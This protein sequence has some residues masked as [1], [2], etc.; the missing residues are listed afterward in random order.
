MQRFN[1]AFQAKK[2][3]EETI[4]DSRG[5]KIGTIRLKPAAILFMPKGT[6]KF[7]S[8]TLDDFIDWITDKETGAELT[9]K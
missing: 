6:G 5:A 4:V 2:F 1:N 8:V 3:H 7:F 9:T